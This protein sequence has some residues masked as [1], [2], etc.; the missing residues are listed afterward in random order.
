MLG[1]GLQRYVCVSKHV[2]YVEVEDKKI[3]EYL[4]RGIEPRDI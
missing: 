2:F 1:I 3:Q 4:D